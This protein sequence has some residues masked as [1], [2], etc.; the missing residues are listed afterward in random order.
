MGEK[1]MWY[2]IQTLGGEEERTAGLIRGQ[3]SSC[4]VEECFVPKIVRMK[5]FNV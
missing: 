1:D 2:V 3:I 4:Y 5:K